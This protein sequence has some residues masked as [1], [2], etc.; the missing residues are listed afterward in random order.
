MSIFTKLKPTTSQEHAFFARSVDIRFNEYIDN[1]N[2]E[3]LLSW[4]SKKFLIEKGLVKP[5]PDPRAK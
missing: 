4:Y 5:P 3:N 1:R 2:K